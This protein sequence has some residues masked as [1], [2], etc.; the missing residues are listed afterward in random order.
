M[1][2]S[3]LRLVPL[4]VG[5]C[6]LGENHVLGDAYSDD[7]RIAFTLYSFLADGGPGRR[8]LVDLGPITLQYT[9]WMFRRY[10]FFRNMPTSPDDVR[11]P[12]GNL[13]DWLGRL[14]VALEDIDHVVLTHLHADHHGMDDGKDGGGMLQ[15]P[16]ARIHI[17]KTG[18]EE[19]LRRRVNS[20]WNSYVDYAFSD[21]LV[22][23]DRQGHLVLQDEGEVV[24][25]MSVTYLGGHSVCSLAVR[26]E[27]PTG[28]AVIC[29]DDVYRYDLLERGIIARLRVSHARL[30]AAT[31]KLVDMAEAGATLLPCHEPRLF[32]L[33]ERSGDD[34]LRDAKMLSDQA[35]AGFRHANRTLLGQLA[36]DVTPPP[37]EPVD[38]VAPPLP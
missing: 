20:R 30:V 37:R 15:L 10:C 11:Q 17:S 2:D 13:F 19:N 32:E 16:N 31:E 23:M 1:P 35:V 9:N 36:G 26:V 21:F 6:A 4:N 28:P 5:E 8:V 7:N 14:G 38:E 3:P 24:P 18:W 12:R 34:W 29:S 25:G 33:Y 27:T 22:E